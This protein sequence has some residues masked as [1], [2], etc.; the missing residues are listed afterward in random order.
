[1]RFELTVNSEMDRK[2]GGP[3]L[4][5]GRGNGPNRYA[6]L[7]HEWVASIGLDVP[8][9]V[10]S[11]RRTKAI[12]IYRRTDNLRGLAPPRTL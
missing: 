7:A 2:V 5:A 9:P 1:M 8:S 3:F 4:F 10:S 6:Q 12:L 11:F